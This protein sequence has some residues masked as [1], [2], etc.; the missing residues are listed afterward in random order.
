MSVY[1]NGHC[2]TLHSTHQRTRL[3]VSRDS[4]VSDL[5]PISEN[6]WNNHPVSPLHVYKENFPS[7][8]KIPGHTVVSDSSSL[9]ELELPV[10]STSSFSQRPD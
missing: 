1:A 5:L 7:L 8:A 4:L 9:A 6:A 2:R 10:Y 3:G